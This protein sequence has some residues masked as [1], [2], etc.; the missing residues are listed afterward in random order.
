MNHQLQEKR[1]ELDQPKDGKSTAHYS[2]LK[3]DGVVTGAL[4]WIS[5]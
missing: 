5:Q 3:T 2:Q 1:N 4:A